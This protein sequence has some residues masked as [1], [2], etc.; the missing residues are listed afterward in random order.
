MSAR[1][2]RSKGEGGLYVLLALCVCVRDL[3]SN[4]APEGLARFKKVMAVDHPR[5][6]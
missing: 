6:K 3:I 5:E 2:L 4:F 1:R